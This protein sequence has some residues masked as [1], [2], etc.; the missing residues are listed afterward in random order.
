MRK[1]MKRWSLAAALVVGALT[2]GCGS[3][4]TDRPQ[5]CREDEYYNEAR[6][7]CMTCPAV[8]E[9]TCRPGCGLEVIS[10]PRGCP[11]LICEEDCQGCDEGESW[12][13]EEEI[14]RDGEEEDAEENE[15]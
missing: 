6:S 15:E 5:D 3:E 9:P 13:E 4:A 10:D 11:L 7:R 2:I 8:F 1:N 14:C 12:D